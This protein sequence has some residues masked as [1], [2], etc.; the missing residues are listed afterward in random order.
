MFTGNKV[1]TG[2][3]LRTVVA[4]HLNTVVSTGELENIREALTRYYIDKGYVNSGALLPDQLVDDGI[5]NFGDVSLFVSA[6]GTSDP[7]ADF[8]GDGVVNIGDVSILVALYGSPPGPSGLV[9]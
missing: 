5:V 8:N 6:F 1:L 7:D 3:E 2:E 4:R 9:P